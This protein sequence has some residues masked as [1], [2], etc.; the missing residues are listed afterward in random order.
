VGTG[1]RPEVYPAQ[2]KP[3]REP[4][5]ELLL[6]LLVPLAVPTEAKDEIFLVVFS[7]WQLGQTGS[8]LASEK[9]II[10]SNAWPH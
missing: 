10:F 9:R 8:R 2:E 1:T 7:L 6:A 3:P 5:L 4:Q